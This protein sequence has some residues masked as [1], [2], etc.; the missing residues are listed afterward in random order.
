MGDMVEAHKKVVER[1]CQC[2]F[3]Q[4]KAINADFV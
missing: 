1:V 4:D 2:L 3:T